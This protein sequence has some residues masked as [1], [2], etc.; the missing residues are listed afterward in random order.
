MGK[1]PISRPET[2]HNNKKKKKW[3]RLNIAEPLII[4]NNMKVENEA[5]GIEIEGEF[6]VLR[7]KALR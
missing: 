5:G 4:H 1:A 2:P 7:G 6:D 3:V